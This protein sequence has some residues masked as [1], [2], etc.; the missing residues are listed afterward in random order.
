[1]SMAPG[2]GATSGRLH[3]QL[4]KRSWLPALIWHLIAAQFRFRVPNFISRYEE[5]ETVQIEST[6]PVPVQIDGDYQ[7][8]W[9]AL[10][11]HILPRA[12]RILVKST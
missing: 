9:T 7:G 10:E 2:A 5:S 6:K 4:R 11:V 8:E 12:A 3:H 1:M